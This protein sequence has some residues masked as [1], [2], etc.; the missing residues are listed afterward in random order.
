MG[1]KMDTQKFVQK[2]VEDVLEYFNVFEEQDVIDHITNARRIAN[3]L[4]GM[5]IYNRMTGGKYLECLC[6][7]HVD[8][9]TLRRD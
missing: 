8:E 4:E 6:P 9:I 7:D 3:H 2:Y 1:R 5:R